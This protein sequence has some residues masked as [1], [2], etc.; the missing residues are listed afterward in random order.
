DPAKPG[1]R[2][3]GA[4]HWRRRRQPAGIHRSCTVCSLGE[5]LLREVRC[6]GLLSPVRMLSC[7]IMYT[8]RW[9]IALLRV[10]VWRI[11]AGG[12]VAG[13]TYGKCRSPP[14]GRVRSTQANSPQFP[15][16]ELYQTKSTLMFPNV[17]S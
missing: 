4:L 6:I 15:Y 1:L 11:H 16:R 12:F 13:R 9:T 17:N 8:G 5:S 10:A 3:E 7:Y 14:C 2:R